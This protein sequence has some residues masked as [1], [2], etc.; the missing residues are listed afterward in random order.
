MRALPIELF[1]THGRIT[2]KLVLLTLATHADQDGTNAWPSL[3]TL[4]AEC[5][6]TRRGIGKVIAWLR[7]HHFLTV[8]YKSK[9]VPGGAVNVYTIT[10]WN[11]RVHS[12]TNT[13]VELQ[14]SQSDG[15][16]WNGGTPDVERKAPDVE[17]QSS[18]DLPIDQPKDLKT[19]VSETRPPKSEVQPRKKKSVSLPDGFGIS[20]RVRAWAR[21]KGFDRL[22]QHLEY[23]VGYARA[24]GKQYADWDAA[25]MNAV[26][27]DWGKV[28]ARSYGN[29]S[30][31]PTL[32]APTRNLMEEAD[33]QRRRLA[34]RG[35]TRNTLVEFR[36]LQD[37]LKTRIPAPDYGRLIRTLAAGCGNRDTMIVFALSQEH[38]DEVIDAYSPILA[39]LAAVDG[40]EAVK[41]HAL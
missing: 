33:Q 7:D 23:F 25:F 10:T 32:P 31:Q 41:V 34:A 27:D 22:D 21:E 12:P 19:P 11:A 24:N 9:P 38:A 29:G 18:H 30:A 14:S 4:A 20:E 26:R 2:R 28:R 15:G 35:F 17:L 39:E 13:D 1:G 16:T 37:R 3:A 40:F 8:A 5:G 36:N 6:L